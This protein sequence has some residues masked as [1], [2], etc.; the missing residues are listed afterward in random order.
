MDIITVILLLVIVIFLFY[1][2]GKTQY[3][4]P[5]IKK[6]YNIE[7]KETFLLNQKQ[8]PIYKKNNSYKKHRDNRRDRIVD[9]IIYNVKDD[10]T[11]GENDTYDNNSVE[12]SRGKWQ[13]PLEQHIEPYRNKIEGV[14][15]TALDALI[16]EV[17]VGN[18]IPSNTNNVNVKIFNS[19]ANHSIDSAKNDYKTSSYS[20]NN[21]LDYNGDG[22]DPLSQDQLD[23]LYND[24]LIFH[25]S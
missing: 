3:E 16:R 4:E 13:N 25:D 2:M 8:N 5:G 20:P 14:D 21:R 18:N 23:K 10:I 19:K 15:Q 11:T 22:I 12:D 7:N 17:N 6:D 24:A 1:K 9:D